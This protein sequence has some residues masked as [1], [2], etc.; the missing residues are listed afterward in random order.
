MRLLKVYRPLAKFLPVNFEFS[1][2]TKR[3]PFSSCD[4]RSPRLRQRA[5]GAFPSA[6]GKTPAG[7]T[8]GSVL[9]PR[10][11]RSGAG[12]VCDPAF[13]LC[14]SY[15]CVALAG[16][17]APGTVATEPSLGNVATHSNLTCALL[18]VPDASHL[19]FSICRHLK[20]PTPQFSFCIAQRLSGAFSNGLLPVPK[21]KTNMNSGQN[22]SY[23]F[24]KNRAHVLSQTPGIS[25]NRDVVFGF[26]GPLYISPLISQLPPETM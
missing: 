17:V 2:S 14:M 9:V 19:P 16:W 26:N 23:S 8:S 6:S 4:S 7:K 13:F 10:H 12:C 21:G 25:W 15:P 24:C 1:L 3:K 20:L 18:C 5:I 11:C 22:N